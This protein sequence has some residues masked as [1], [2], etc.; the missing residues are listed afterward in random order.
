MA[1]EKYTPIK[2]KYDATLDAYTDVVLF[3]KK[4]ER[5]IAIVEKHGLPNKI[6]SKSLEFHRKKQS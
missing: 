3:P 2:P 5:A 6:P 1:T 4:M